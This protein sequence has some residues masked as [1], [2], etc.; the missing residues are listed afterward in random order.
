VQTQ[1]V[2]PC[3]NE[4]RRLDVP[5]FEA[6]LGSSRDVGLIMVNDGSE[7]D[8]LRVLEGLASRWPDRVHVID[9]QPNAG[10][11]EAVRNGMLHAF[12]TGAA[13][14]GYFDA[15][16]ATP[17]D[18]VREFVARLDQHPEIDIVI[19]ARL[20]LL[21]RKIDRSAKRH[22]LGRVFA[23]AASIVL[24]LPVY[25][26]QCGAKLFRA[27]EPV[28][29]LFGRPFGSRWIFDV[30]IFARY[31]AGRGRREALYELP[32]QQWADIGE[33]RVKGI[34]FVRAIAEMASIYRT[35]G[36][37]RDQRFVM[38]LATSRAIRYASV[39]AIGTVVHYVT[40]T[41]AV[42]VFHQPVMLATTA[43]SLLGAIVNY[44]LNY[45]F[46]FAS[47]AAHA[48][49]FPRFVTVAALSAGLN[50]VGMWL[51]VQVLKIHYLVAQLACTFAVLVFGYLLN[52]LW[53]FGAAPRIVVS[54]VLEAPAS[55]SAVASRAPGA[56]TLEGEMQVPAA[57]S[58]R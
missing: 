30:E 38:R 33:S 52:K 11:A 8:T 39:G 18:A 24:D 16:L 45:H 19:G 10:K 23:T 28:R 47:K 51:A 48:Y 32:L 40:L 36:L 41:T 58:D 49:T 27:T 7:D 3:Y 17:L 20:M 43:G 14:S 15:D 12:E 46:T 57:S 55:S 25:D 29:E 6:F 13:Y 56:T 26:T 34:D 22:Y 31:L 2:V 4:G 5:A 1:I 42:E 44:I 50:F 35:Y 53:T 54:A 37:P 9:Q 21:G